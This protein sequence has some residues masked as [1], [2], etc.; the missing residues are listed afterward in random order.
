MIPWQAQYWQEVVAWGAKA[1]AMFGGSDNLPAAMILVG[2]E[3]W[4]ES[5][6]RGEDESIRSIA[7]S[8]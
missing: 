8:N 6:S 2:G 1:K 5:D 4:P 7:S 3:V